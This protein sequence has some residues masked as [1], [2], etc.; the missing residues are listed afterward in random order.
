MRLNKEELIIGA[1]YPLLLTPISTLAMLAC[2]I[3]AFLWAYSGAGASKLWRRLAI[4]TFLSILI[5]FHRHNGQVFYAVP[6]AFAFLSIGYG[7]PSKND[8]GSTLGKFFYKLFN[9]NTVLSN[10]FVRGIIYIGS[11]L[12]FYLLSRSH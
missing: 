1:V 4:P 11:L 5:F 10:I 8:S 7:I 6:I 2:P 12:P 3:S 9:G